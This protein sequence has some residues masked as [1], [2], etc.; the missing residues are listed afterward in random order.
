MNGSQAYRS[1]VLGQGSG[2]GGA[3]RASLKC[4]HGQSLAGDPAGGDGGVIR[5]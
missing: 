3:D 2:G 1:P 4:G 5:V